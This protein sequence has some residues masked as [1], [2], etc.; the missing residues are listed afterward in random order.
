[1][2]TA[3]ALAEGAFDEFVEGRSRKFFRFWKEDEEAARLKRRPGA[4]DGGSW[5]DPLDTDS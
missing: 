5:S 2:F 4:G 3:D 1:V